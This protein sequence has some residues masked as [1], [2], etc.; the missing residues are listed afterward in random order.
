M[1]ASRRERLEAAAGRVRSLPGR[2]RSLP[3]VND[4]DEGSSL[5]VHSRDVQAEGRWLRCHLIL[6]ETC[7]SKECQSRNET[8]APGC[9]EGTTRSRPGG[10]AIP[11]NSLRDSLALERL[12]LKGNSR[13]WARE[14][15]LLLCA[16]MRSCLEPHAWMMPAHKS[17]PTC[18]L[19]RRPQWSP[20]TQRPRG[21]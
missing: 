15:I 2:V 14:F 3:C 4:K 19:E 7:F 21:P 1:A 20:E 10:G 5:P 17:S 13:A 16:R 8:W 6:G 18:S 12:R 11:P 9:A